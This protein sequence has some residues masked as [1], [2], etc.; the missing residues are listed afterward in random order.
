MDEVFENRKNAKKYLSDQ[1][2]FVI[3]ADGLEERSSSSDS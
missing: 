2:P 3:K 1:P